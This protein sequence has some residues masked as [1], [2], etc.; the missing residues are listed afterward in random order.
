MPDI[1]DMFSSTYFKTNPDY[2]KIIAWTNREVDKYN[3]IVR[4]H[5]FGEGIPKIIPGDKLTADAPYIEDKVALIKNN[6]DMEVVSAT[7][8]E[9]NVGPDLYIKVYKSVV[10]VFGLEGDTYDVA[11]KI[12]HEDSDT[13]FKAVLNLLK[14]RAL[15]EVKGTYKHKEAWREFYR[16]KDRYLRAKYSYAI[17]AHKS[18]GSSY[19]HTVVMMYDIIKNN[20]TE[21]RNRILYTACTRPRYTLKIVY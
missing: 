10:K 20:K 15:A 3:K 4:T 16:F 2:V 14:T 18:Q 17:T 5:L 12:L 21:E 13:D 11:V 9:D 6:E 19:D 8:E 1:L 7:I